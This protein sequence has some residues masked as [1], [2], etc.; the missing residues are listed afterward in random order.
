MLP[1]LYGLL[2]NHGDIDKLQG[3]SGVIVAGEACT[4][5]LCKKHFEILPGTEL[6][7]EYGPTEASVWC[8]AHKITRDDLKGP[9]PIGKP[10]ANTEVYILNDRAGLTNGYLN[11]PEENQKHFVFWPP[12]SK[13]PSR[14]YRSGDLVRYDKKGVLQFLGRK[15][16]QVKVRGFRIELDE[17]EKVILGST[18]V[19]RAVVC[20]EGVQH[21]S[22]SLETSSLK[23][24][25]VF[26]YIEENLSLSEVDEL[27]KSI[28]ILNE[29]EQD[30]LYDKL[31]D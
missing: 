10:I 15:D 17:V 1:S 26:R 4:E 8:I 14:L 24:Q 13:T 12:N 31:N 5:R 19:D 6:F 16:Q 30:F 18:L 21:A 3:L 20:V 7:N 23:T 28:E 27:L 11:L 29:K 25:D 22:D 9:I 2:L